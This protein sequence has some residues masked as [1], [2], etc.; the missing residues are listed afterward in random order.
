MIESTIEYKIP[1]KD[2]IEGIEYV[3]D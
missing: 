2:G 3:E 1:F